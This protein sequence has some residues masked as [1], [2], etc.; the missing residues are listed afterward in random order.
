MD[1]LPFK[2][3][4]EPVSSLGGALV[5]VVA[6]ER[7]ELVQR[8]VAKSKASLG[9][10]RKNSASEGRRFCRRAKPVILWRW[11]GAGWPLRRGGL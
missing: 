11:V 10:A 8:M 7:S 5:S 2:I 4:P 1:A 6:G 9:L 3:Q